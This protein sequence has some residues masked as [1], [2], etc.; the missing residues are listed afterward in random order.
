MKPIGGLM[1]TTTL[2][3]TLAD[4]V[5]PPQGGYTAKMEPC[6]VH[7]DY[8]LAEDM[9]AV[10]SEAVLRR[11]AA[12]VSYEDEIGSRVA[13]ALKAKVVDENTDL[14]KV[15][16][17]LIPQCD[18]TK[19]SKARR[20]ALT[21]KCMQA[22]VRFIWNCRLPADLDESRISEPD[23]L[24]RMGTKVAS[25]GNWAY[26]PGDVK[27]HKELEGT[28]EPREWLVSALDNPGFDKAAPTIIGKGSPRRDD[29]MQLA[30]YHRHLQALG[31]AQVTPEVWGSIIGKSGA[32]LWRDVA[33]EPK[34]GNS[35]L[36]EY[37]EAFELRKDVIRR[38]LAMADDA[39]LE[40]LVRFEWK[41]ECQECPWRVVCKDDLTAADHITLL[42]GMT[43][44]RASHHYEVGIE[45]RQDLARL[46]HATAYLV[47]RGVDVPALQ[48][49]ALEADPATP[50]TDLLAAQHANAAKSV[51]IVTAGD[52]SKLDA[53]T[54][55]YSN[56]KLGHSLADT[57]D[58]AR[59]T[60]AQEVHLRRGIRKMDIPRADI[61]LDVDM[62]NGDGIVYLW[63]TNLTLRRKGL[64][65]P[66]NAYRPF[67]TFEP[68]D[69]AGEAAAFRDLW[70]WITTLK[71]VAV[72]TQ[73][74][75]K[76][77]CY[78]GAENR[79][80]LHLAKSHA[81][82]PGIPTLEEVEDFLKSEHWVDLHKVISEQT[83]WPTENLTLKSTAKW[84]R[85]SW[86]ESG[87]NGDQSVV[88]YEAATNGD[89]VCKA[90]VLDYNEDDVNATL[91]LRNWLSSLTKKGAA[92]DRIQNVSA[93]DQRFRRR[94][95]SKA[96]R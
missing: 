46:D 23:Y 15:R 72:N 74:S 13:S 57:I 33:K 7:N 77:Y 73:S 69:A 81:G 24:V 89:E 37:D 76:A 86:R 21:L 58:Q 52:V 66:G 61:E 96:K 59:V 12:G 87:A 94:R 44:R 83:L 47:D 53:L 91:H 78:T 18:R 41:S 43:P 9:A 39:S 26:A 65:F 84:A 60:I 90:K 17:A 54:A 70:E 92:E 67:A 34:T 36:S 45:T 27:H 93:L 35:V 22:G 64:K 31:H 4:Y 68:N 71:N 38:A 32:M 40:P 16:A 5:V 25:N 95:A 62:E 88:W 20:E 29:S 50:L 56:R 55:R 2:E 14:S 8:V 1:T 28:S 3:L 85:F 82:K 51:G 63:G 42:Q 10:D 79:C 75:F 30:H 49:A 11:K 6:R 19:E 80:M 48:R